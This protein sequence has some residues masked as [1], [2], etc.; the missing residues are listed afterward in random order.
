MIL[1]L[2]CCLERR[3][4][5]DMSEA[6]REGHVRFSPWPWR[7]ISSC[8]VWIKVGVRQRLK[9]MIKTSGRRKRRAMFVSAASSPGEGLIKVE[10]EEFERCG[11]EMLDLF[12]LA[13]AEW[14]V[15]LH[16]G[17]PHKWPTEE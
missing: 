6:L 15:A 13:D 1:L 9:R 5:Y 2:V 3:P 4:C 10:A 12:A 8:R 16:A 7:S 17:V 11:E 14:R